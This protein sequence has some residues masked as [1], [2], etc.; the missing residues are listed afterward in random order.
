MKKTARSFGVFLGRPNAGEENSDQLFALCEDEDL[1]RS[2]L[3]VERWA[4]NLFW[5]TQ[6]SRAAPPLHARPDAVQG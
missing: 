2:A 5:M 6:H 1:G 3:G 4:L